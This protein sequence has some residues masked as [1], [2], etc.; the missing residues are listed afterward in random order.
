MLK[1]FRDENPYSWLSWFTVCARIVGAVYNLRT[2]TV[3]QCCYYTDFLHC[4]Q[5]FVAGV[6]RNCV[7]LMLVIVT[8]VSIC[9]SLTQIITKLV[10]LIKLKFMFWI[11]LFRTVHCVV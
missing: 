4:D 2:P 8:I 5:D 1:Y 11:G 3:C 10:L 9:V 7:T 6:L